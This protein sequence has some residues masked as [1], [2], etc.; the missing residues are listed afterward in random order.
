MATYI[1]FL[2]AINVGSRYVKMQ[3]LRGHLEDAG[4]GSV[5]THIQT[6]NV[7][8]TSRA[9]SAGAV[10]TAVEKTL[11]DALGFEVPSI[12]RTPSELA[13]VVREAPAS[14][15]GEAARHYLFLLKETPSTSAAAELDGWAVDGER[16]LVAGRDVHLWTTTPFHKVKASNARVEKLASTA[17]TARDWKVVSTLAQKWASA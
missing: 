13:A 16:M 5:E 10:A 3:D 2:R 17:S 14:P 1:V 7:R 8:V 12:V 4:F 11:R 6:G 9:R 15:L